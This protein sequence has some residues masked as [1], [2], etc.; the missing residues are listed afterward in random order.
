LGGRK[1]GKKGTLGAE[2]FPIKASDQ[3]LTIR[4]SV[5]PGGLR[6]CR[7]LGAETSAS[8]RLARD[9]HATGSMRASTSFCIAEAAHTFFQT[10]LLLTERSHSMILG[11]RVEA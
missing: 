8:S 7:Q 2:A 4:I 10:F 11:N 5:H 3:L 1:P 6:V 9:L